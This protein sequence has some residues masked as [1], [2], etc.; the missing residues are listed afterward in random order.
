MLRTIEEMPMPEAGRVLKAAIVGLAHLHPRSYMPLFKAVEATQV[1]AAVEAD[2]AL[3]EAFCRDFSVRGYD[4]VE[5]MLAAERPDIAAIFLPHADCPAAAEACA[6]AG[7]HLM[8]EKP[9]A[10]SAEGARRIAAAGRRHDVKVTTGYCWRL[11]P[12]AR[13]FKRL[14]SSGAIGRPVGAEGRCAAGRLQRY[15]DGHASWM[16]QQAKSGGGPMYNLGVHWIDLFRWLLE[17]EV[18]EVSG[19]NVKVNTAYDIEDNSFAHLRFTSGAI[20]ALDISYTIPDAFP[21]GRDL[22]LSVRGTQGA[23]SWAPA[24]EG[25][26]D[27]LAVCSDHPDFAG[28]PRRELSFELEKVAG[29]SGAMGLS[30]VRD[31]VD[32]VRTG[33]DPQITAEDGVRALD[34][35]EAVYESAGNNRWTAVGEAE[36]HGDRR[37]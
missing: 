2:E 1:T 19:R 17:D 24:Y 16:L 29:Y 34:V 18:A 36:K 7:A 6:A 32:A 12:A 10:A 21:H 8:V 22:Y 25:Q 11:H 35:V 20:A 15:I 33:R 23:V 31:F 26:K 5:E 3:R 30:Y 9:M 14:V 28:A 4:S 37:S 13:E 27:V